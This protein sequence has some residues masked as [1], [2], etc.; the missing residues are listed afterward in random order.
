[1]SGWGRNCTFKHTNH[2]KTN[3]QS[4]QLQNNFSLFGCNS[5]TLCGHSLGC[6]P[7]ST[8]LKVRAPSLLLA[9]ASAA[10]THRR[11]EGT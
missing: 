9:A 7:I 6:R 11:E 2:M 5:H 4:C 8:S 1:M 3:L 10:A